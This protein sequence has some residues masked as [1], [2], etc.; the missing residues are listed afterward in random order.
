L[1]DRVVQY[2]K[3]LEAMVMEKVEKLAA[4]QAD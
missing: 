4:D 3:G 2:K 1:L